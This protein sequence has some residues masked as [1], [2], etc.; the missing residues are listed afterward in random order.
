MTPSRSRKQVGR[1]RSRAE[2]AAAAA[3]ATG[4]VAATVLLVWLLRPGRVGVPGEG[5]L[6]A[7]QPRVGLWLALSAAALGAGVWWARH[8]RRRP[9]RLSGRSLVA[10]TVAV[11]GAASAAAG[12]FWPGGLQRHYPSLPDF[13]ELDTPAETAPEPPASAPTTRAPRTTPAP[14]TPGT[15]A[16]APTTAATGTNTGGS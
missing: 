15:T 2:V 9:R 4:I 8:G 10:V 1:L 12:V 14:T 16:S 13:D 11:V 7:R 6:L 3:V 5:G